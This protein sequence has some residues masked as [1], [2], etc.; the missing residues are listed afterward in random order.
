[1]VFGSVAVSFRGTSFK[2]HWLTNPH[3]LI[4]S[5]VFFAPKQNY[6]SSNNASFS[7]ASSSSRF[8][9]SV[10]PESANDI[11]SSSVSE[12]TSLNSISIS[13]SIIA[14][15]N[16]ENLN[17]VH[18]AL[19]LD[20]DEL[21]FVSQMSNEDSSGYSSEPWHQKQLT[22]T[23]SSLSSIF[24][25]LGCNSRKLS[26]ESIS[27]FSSEH[28]QLNRRILKNLSTSFEN[29]PLTSNNSSISSLNMNSGNMYYT[30]TG[31]SVNLNGMSDGWLSKVRRNSEIFVRRKTSSG[32]ALIPASSLNQRKRSRLAIAVVVTM[33]ENIED[34][35][36]TFCVEHAVLFESM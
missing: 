31:T 22:S 17:D 2:I 7:A 32:D 34:A 1:M 23:R 33:N 16:N 13:E 29:V 24:S 27:E 11:T 18:A 8:S 15:K 5:Q 21:R 28:E 26:V 10:V 19:S 36:N 14:I 12:S 20:N 25:D 30:I 9:T 6:N 35:M 4:C 3:R